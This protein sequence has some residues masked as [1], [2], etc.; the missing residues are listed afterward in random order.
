MT[1][2]FG[3]YRR[4]QRHFKVP[5]YPGELP[6]ERDAGW[7][8]PSR[9]AL[10]AISALNTVNAWRP[11]SRRGRLSFLCFVPAWITTEL[12]LQSLATQVAV[13]AALA[14]RSRS[15][16]KK[17][18]IALGLTAASWAGMLLLR[19]PAQ[20][21]GAVLDAALVEGFGV[22]YGPSAAAPKQLPAGGDAGQPGVLRMMRIHSQFA[23][24]QDISYGPEGR[25]NLLDVWRRQDL[26]PSGKSPVLLHVPGGGWMTG[27]KQG[28]AHPLMS[29]LASRGWVCVSISYRLAPK[30]TWPAAIM[31]VKG[32]LCWVKDHISEYGGDPD[33][34]CITGGS[35]GGHLSSLAALTAESRDF[36]PG[37]EDRDLSVRA[38]VPFYGV[39]DWVDDERIGNTGLAVSLERWIVKQKLQDNREVFE[40][41]SPYFR[42]TS[43]APPFFVLHG[44]SDAVA[45][46]EQARAFV[47]RMRECS[48]EPVVYAELPFAQHAFDLFS[49]LRA[50]HSARAVERFLGTVHARYTQVG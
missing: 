30:A 35:A 2:G 18:A 39:Y 25:F 23:H 33:F 48:A 24:E 29:H 41:A 9:L 37:F 32:A 44:T 50:N 15:I 1:P 36:Q 46:V 26:S 43:S 3:P 7:R 47:K 5:L 14:R 40:R 31:D 20:E 27:S 42:V 8:G 22:G 38:A 10:A 13:A 19:R 45:S 4:H 12:P 17:D 21:S 16:T 11:L 49:S 6:G 34:V 28:Q